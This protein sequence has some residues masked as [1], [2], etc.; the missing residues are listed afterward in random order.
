MTYIYNCLEKLLLLLILLLLLLLPAH[1][2]TQVSLHGKHKTRNSVLQQVERQGTLNHLTASSLHL[3]LSAIYPL[4]SPSER[5]SH[6]TQ[7]QKRMN[8]PCVTVS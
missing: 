8:E 7:L 2:G 3:N 6:M 1:E 4:G 5:T